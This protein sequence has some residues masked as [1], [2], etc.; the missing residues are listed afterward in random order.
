MMK[1]FGSI[2]F[3]VFLCLAAGILTFLLLREIIAILSINALRKRKERGAEH[4]CDLLCERF[5]NATVYRN[6][7]LLK[8]SAA[9]QGLKCACDVVY[10]SRGGVLLLTV[11]PDIG[12]YD[13][14]K[15]GA[16]RYRYINTQKE[17]I[18]LQKANPFDRMSFFSSVVEKLL[19]SENLLN[20]SVTRAVVFSADLVDYTTDYPECLTVAT[21]F[22]YVNAFNRR[23]HFNRSEYHKACEVISACSE[24]LESHLPEDVKNS[25]DGIS[26]SVPKAVR[27]PPEKN[28]PGSTAP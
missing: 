10:I 23:R 8:E 11:F 25:K 9:E 26:P 2:Y 24:Y 5:P 21:L 20:P 18:T 3:I 27:K 17:T 13:N 22:D 28:H 19:V 16:W 7:Y 14:P 12:V 6:V 1:F 15:I 4:I